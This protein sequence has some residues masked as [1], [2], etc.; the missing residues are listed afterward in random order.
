MLEKDASSSGAGKTAYPELEIQGRQSLLALG[1][2]FGLAGVIFALHDGQPDISQDLAFVCACQ[3]GE[4]PHERQALEAVLQ[5]LM[6][7]CREHVFPFDISTRA[8]VQTLR[9]LCAAKVSCLAIPLHAPGNLFA[10]LL[11][12]HEAEYP[13]DDALAELHLA[14]VR[15]FET[16][17]RNFKERGKALASRL[18][19]R[20]NECLFWCA[21]GKSYWETSRILGISERTVN[22]HMS[23]V[24]NKL[25][26]LTNAQA[27]ALASRGGLLAQDFPACDRTGKQAP[28]SRKHQRQAD[29]G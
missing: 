5:P 23:R 12:L 27:V 2:E 4:R 21:K 25:G 1:E 13:M 10:I 7:V 26:V 22:H 14:T 9:N 24:R 8:E 20:E 18:T 19:R 3:D 16:F 6:E 28:A 15:Y 17:V 11:A 29:Q